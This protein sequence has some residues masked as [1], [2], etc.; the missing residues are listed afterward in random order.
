[1]PKPAHVLLFSILAGSSLAMGHAQEGS[2]VVNHTDGLKT[3][4]VA[5]EE[6]SDSLI[7]VPP[8]TSVHFSPRS[9]KKA[10]GA[11][12][13]D[14]PS[15][16]SKEAGLNGL[17]STD[18][19]PWHIVVTY[20]QFDEDGDNIHSGVYE[21]YWVGPKKY[22]RIYKSDNFNQTDY[23]TDKG[24]YRRGDQKWPDRTQSQIRAEVVAPFY[25]GATLQQGFHARIMERSF[26][27]NR[28]Q[29]VL[30]ERDQVISDPTQYCFEPGVSALRYSR[31]LGWNQTVYNDIV[32]FQGRNLARRVDVTD[33][34]KRYLD[35][36]VETVE[37][38]QNIV[39][40]D[41]VPPPEAAGPMGGRV[42]DVS[43]RPVSTS[44]FPRWPASLR[45]QHVAVTVRIVIG[46]DGHVLKARGVSGPPEAYKAC[47]DAVRNWVYPPFLV[48]DRP[49]EVEQN[50][51]FHTF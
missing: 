28:F 9:E 38:I 44:G 51:E 46:K 6:K 32:S 31:G 34:G 25:Y 1:M 24:L 26:S 5:A 15:W 23:A 42:S 18:L 19:S 40:A 22:K 30:I 7:V 2:P 20:D 8:A 4:V 43:L 47:E 45:G 37:L 36:R 39:E 14:L 41:F 16:L 11:D 27:G 50:V 29:C 10:A 17:E 35:L 3:L 49:V 13:V 33:G 12:A 21:E 48:L